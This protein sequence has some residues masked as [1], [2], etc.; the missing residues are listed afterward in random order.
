MRNLPWHLAIIGG[1]VVI[2][3]GVA[4]GWVAG[5]VVALI[6]AGI[7]ASSFLISMKANGLLQALRV[8]TSAING[9]VE[10]RTREDC[11]A[12]YLYMVIAGREFQI[13]EELYGKLHDGD[14]VT[15]NF[16]EISDG[17]MD[18]VYRKPTVDTLN[19][20]AAI[21]FCL[22]VVV[23]LCAAHGPART[24]DFEA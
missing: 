13:S 5:I 21:G 20:L 22:G 7:L 24:E 12:R 17:W 2:A 15:V 14:R 4:S 9:E 11:T 1:A 18:S 6:G 10:R 19:I 16:Y 3:A 23:V 8:G